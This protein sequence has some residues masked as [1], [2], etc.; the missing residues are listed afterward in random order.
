MYVI[1]AFVFQLDGSWL[2]TE[3]ERNMDVSQSGMSVVD[4]CSTIFDILT[5]SKTDEQLQNDV[6]P[7][8]INVLRRL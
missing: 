4:M 3:V 1:L 6:R 7:H 5:S 2:R 8:A